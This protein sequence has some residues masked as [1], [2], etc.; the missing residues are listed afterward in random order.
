M[1]ARCRVSGQR[2]EALTTAEQALAFALRNLALIQ[3]KAEVY[4]A[5][6]DLDRARAW[7]KAAER[8]VSPDCRSSGGIGRIHAASRPPTS[9]SSYA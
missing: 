7:I 1:L 3:H 5:Q 6:G 9:S 4:V 2:R 8:R